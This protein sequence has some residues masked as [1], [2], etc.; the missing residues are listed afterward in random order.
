MRK[1]IFIVACIPALVL[2]QESVKSEADA[3]L[4]ELFPIDSITI[5][6][7]VDNIKKQDFL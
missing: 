1:L 7:I 4:G 2:A 5:E 6:A 3:I